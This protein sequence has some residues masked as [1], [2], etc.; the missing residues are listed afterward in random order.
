MYVE[1]IKYVD[2]EGNEG[3]T[4]VHFNLNKMEVV[5]IQWSV[6]G[7]IKQLFEKIVEE[8]DIKKILE[9]MEEIL[10]KAFGIKSPDGKR[11]MKPADGWTEFK[12]GPAYDDWM[13]GVLQDPGKAATIMRAI[14]PEIESLELKRQE[15]APEISQ[16]GAS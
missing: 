5:N 15:Q 2:F 14:M 4:T 1:K 12:E 9:W 11:F 3:V 13:F 8:Q 6:P 10:S 16:G 7:G